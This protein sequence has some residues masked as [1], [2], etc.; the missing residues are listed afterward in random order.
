MV[1]PVVAPELDRN[2]EWQLECPEI[3]LVTLL[4]DFLT[5]LWKICGVWGRVG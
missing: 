1:A 4:S 5:D 2:Y 3:L